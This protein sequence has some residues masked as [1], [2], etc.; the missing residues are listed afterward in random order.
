MRERVLLSSQTRKKETN[1]KEKSERDE[2]FLWC[3]TNNEREKRI[4]RDKKRKF[5]SRVF[6]HHKK[7]SLSFT[8]KE[9]DTK[10]KQR[11]KI[12]NVVI[13]IDTTDESDDGSGGSGGGGGSGSGGGGGGVGGSGG[14]GGE[15]SAAPG[16]AGGTLWMSFEP[17]P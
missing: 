15:S 3:E 6:T 11:V 13:V 14:G 9:G 10:T 4:K 7:E 5:R 12:K 2:H 17:S 8:P 1:A 16:R